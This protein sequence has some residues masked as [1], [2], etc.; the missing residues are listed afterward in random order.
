ML[1]VP[2]RPGPESVSHSVLHVRMACNAPTMAATLRT[3]VR[4]IL[5]LVALLVA[6]LPARRASKVEHASLAA[7]VI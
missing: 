6:Y 3:L 4:E 5:G 7:P 2:R 1:Y